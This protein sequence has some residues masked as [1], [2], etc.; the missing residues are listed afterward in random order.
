VSGPDARARWAAATELFGQALDRPD[1]E[2]AAF[3][4]EAAKDDPALEA[5]V[6]SLLDVSARAGDFL[7]STAA[8]PAW[9]SARFPRG[10]VV[11]HYRIVT[12]VGAG[13]MGIVYLAEDTT[14]GRLV[15]LK[16][17]DP[18]VSGDP[19]RV[20]RLRREARAAAALNHPHIAT[21]YAL[22]EFDGEL[23][24][25][26]EYVPGATLREDLARGALSGRAV[27]D[28][29]RQI[30]DALESAHRRGIVHRDLKPE[31]VVRLADGHVR[32]L[33]FGLAQFEDEPGPTRLTGEGMAGTPA[34]MAP[35]Q[36]RG[37][38]VDGRA[39]LFALGIVG[40]EL[41]A[42]RHPFAAPTPAATIASILQDEPAP[43]VNAAGGRDASLHALLTA[44]ILRCLRKDPQERFQ[45]AGDVVTALDGVA[46]ASNVETG[47]RAAIPAPRAARWWWQFHQG[48]TIAAY[49]LVLVLLWMARPDLP[50]P[51]GALLLLTGVAATVTS[52]AVRLH[53]MFAVRHLA[54]AG[55]AAHP[56]ARRTA[57][58]ADAAFAGTLLGAGLLLIGADDQTA[59]LL[60]AA[61]AA[62]AVSFLVVEPATTRAAFP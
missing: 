21:V 5:E 24:L 42:G 39:D 13:G 34:Y 10:H 38:V 23:Y 41:L 37:A 58:V 44:V 15:A 11:G 51:L 49:G 20:A 9:S 48:V 22:E 55:P 59:A 14:L 57:W 61:A 3:V 60:V 56:A 43:P 12:I 8:R 50:G 28:V 29:L 25:A 35:E 54:S 16:A 2:R 33:D 62:I 53:V 4:R 31:N 30:A 7:S 45:R 32:I 26:S 6:L 27:R 1:A 36:I 18:A 52:G 40:Y 19:V 17:V 46:M 47:G